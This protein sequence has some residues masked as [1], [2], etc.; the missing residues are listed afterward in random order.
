MNVLGA[1]TWMSFESWPNGPRVPATTR[2][3][4]GHDTPFTAPANAFTMRRYCAG[5]W[6]VFPFTRCGVRSLSALGSFQTSQ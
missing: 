4:G 2:F 5:A 6:L 1:M 3:S